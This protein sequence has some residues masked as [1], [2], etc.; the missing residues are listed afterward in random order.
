MTDQSLA[1]NLRIV[2]GRPT[3]AELAAVR[4]VLARTLEEAAAEHEQATEPMPSAWD[5]SR[6][7]LR[8][9]LHPAP[10]AWRS[11]AG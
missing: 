11:F 8:A 10:G 7:A 4:A 9:P 5:R 6:V 1:A 2:A 3:P